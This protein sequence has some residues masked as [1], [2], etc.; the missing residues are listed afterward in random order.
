MD[1]KTAVPRADQ[2]YPVSVGL[3]AWEATLDL[4]RRFDRVVLAVAVVAGGGWLIHLLMGA[5][6][7]PVLV[8]TAAGVLG[9]PVMLSCI[10]IL[11]GRRGC[12][13]FAIS[14]IIMVLFLTA[15]CGVGFGALTSLV[16]L[17]LPVPVFFE[18]AYLIPGWAAWH[19]MAVGALA[20]IML[21]HVVTFIWP[22]SSTT[23]MRFAEAFMEY[24]RHRENLDSLYDVGK[25]RTHTVVLAVL[26]ILVPVVCLLAPVWFA[27][28]AGNLFLRLWP[29]RAV[30]VT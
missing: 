9:C 7:H 20:T 16:W 1:T 14:T 28:Y 25:F 11:W 4:V 21:W 23:P 29:L 2:G 8:L 19:L 17:L 6:A 27:L 15:I 18:G 5:G 12:T 30:P 22:L 13:R 24:D 10:S 26:A 3:V